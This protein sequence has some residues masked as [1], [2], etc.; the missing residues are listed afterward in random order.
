VCALHA[1]CVVCVVRC[2]RFVCGE[3]EVCAMNESV[4]GGEVF[5]VVWFAE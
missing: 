5:V 1:V 4:R 3:Y 2:V